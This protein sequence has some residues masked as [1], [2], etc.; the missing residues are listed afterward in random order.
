MPVNRRAEMKRLGSGSQPHAF[1]AA[2]LD[3]T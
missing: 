2:K 1:K 3:G